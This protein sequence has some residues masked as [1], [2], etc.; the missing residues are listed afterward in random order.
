M[1]IPAYVVEPAKVRTSSDVK[2][3]F[4]NLSFSNSFGHGSRGRIF[5]DASTRAWNFSDF[6]L[7]TIATN[8][9]NSLLK[10]AGSLL[11]ETS[12]VFEELIFQ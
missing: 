3:G 11:A 6:F 5:S 7:F 10:P 4:R 8:P 2:S 1:L 9:S 12:S